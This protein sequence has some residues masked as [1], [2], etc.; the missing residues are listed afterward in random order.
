MEGRASGE[1]ESTAKQARK[2]EFLVGA[3]ADKLANSVGP[4]SLLQAP[5][6]KAV[7]PILNMIRNSIKAT[8]E[9]EDHG[10]PRVPCDA[11]CD[12][13]AMR[14]TIGITCCIATLS[15]CVALLRLSRPCSPSVPHPRQAVFEPTGGIRSSTVP[16]EYE[17]GEVGTNAWPV[18]SWWTRVPSWVDVAPGWWDKYTHTLASEHRIAGQPDPRL[19][20]VV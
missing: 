2:A 16:L 14:H 12:A 9:Y 20:N 8:M 15:P 4:P 18:P 5:Y 1:M 13:R 7:Y 10:E 3:P 19:F 11:P 17:D 6:F